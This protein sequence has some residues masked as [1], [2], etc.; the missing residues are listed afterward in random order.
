MQADLLFRYCSGTADAEEK[1]LV[2][3]MLSESEE[4]SLYVEQINRLLALDLD[5]KEYESYPVAGA[6]K[7]VSDRIQ[8]KP[9]ST[10]NRR[11]QLLSRFRKYAAILFIPLLMCSFLLGYLYMTKDKKEP[12]SFVELCTPQGTITRYE[13]PDKSIVWLN[14]GSWIRHP[15]RFDGTVREVSLKGEAY[16]EV[17]ADKEHPFYVNLSNGM[18]VFAHGTKFNVSSYDADGYIEA[19]L[20]R[21][22]IGVVTP[23]KNE[24]LLKKT[25]E[26]VLFDKI[27]LQSKVLESLDVYEKTAWKD[28]KIIFRNTS[29]E[30]VLKRLSRSYNVDITFENRSE[31]DF[32]YRATF[33]NENINQI[34]DYLSQSAK[35]R[36]EIQEP[37]QKEDSTFT[38][39]KILVIQ[40]TGLPQRK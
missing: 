14:S 39:K 38:R 19:F 2:E 1:L 34:L 9:N 3:R 6:Y 32:H 31:K 20:E 12:V 23:D 40:E 25:G 37:V 29:L 17:E 16:F 10:I 8:S 15:N 11:I 26:G 24:I 33:T 21:G 13:L 27:S 35:I 7:K 30:D 5:K 28:G 22:K 36:W 4:S 18:K